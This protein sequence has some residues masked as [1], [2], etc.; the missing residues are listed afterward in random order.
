MEHDVKQPKR[1]WLETL[2][3]SIRNPA[4][5]LAYPPMAVTRSGGSPDNRMGARAKELG[6]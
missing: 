4:V 3:D 2:R 1:H 6:A 5:R